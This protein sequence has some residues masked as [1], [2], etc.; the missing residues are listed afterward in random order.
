MDWYVSLGLS[1]EDLNLDTFWGKY[2][3]LC[4]PQTNKVCMPTLILLQASD[5][6]VKAW[7]N[8]IM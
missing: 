4:K 8:G 2:D 6:E 7:M 1:A 5:K 3:E